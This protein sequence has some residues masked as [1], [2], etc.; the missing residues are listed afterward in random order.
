MNQIIDFL[1]FVNQKVL[2]FFYAAGCK[3]GALILS[4]SAYRKCVE[5]MSPWLPDGEGTGASLAELPT[6]IGKVRIEIDELL[7]GFHVGFASVQPK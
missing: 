3:P 6:P 4:P 5:Q 7:P 1:A 2:D